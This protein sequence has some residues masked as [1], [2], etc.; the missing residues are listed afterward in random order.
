[1]SS[2]FFLVY[3]VIDLKNKPMKLCVTYKIKLFDGVLGGLSLPSFRRISNNK[4]GQPTGFR[5]FRH[6]RLP[7]FYF[8]DYRHAV[9]IFWNFEEEENRKLIFFFQVN[10]DDKKSFKIFGNVRDSYRLSD[11][12]LVNIEVSVTFDKDSLHHSH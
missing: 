8:L 6:F 10:A 3:G 2:I 4:S 9:P 5:H 1:M 12:I 11:S 7:L